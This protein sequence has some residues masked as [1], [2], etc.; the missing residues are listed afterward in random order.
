MRCKRPV[1]VC[2]FSSLHYSK[3]NT[4]RRRTMRCKRCRSRLLFGIFLSSIGLDLFPLKF[5]YSIYLISETKHLRYRS[6]INSLK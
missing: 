5:S 6:F 2:V 4:H 1:C 3:L